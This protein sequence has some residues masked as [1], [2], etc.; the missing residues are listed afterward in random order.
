M[1]GQS[2]GLSDG[3]RSVNMYKQLLGSPD[4]MRQT[5]VYIPDTHGT[6]IYAYI[7]VVEQASMQTYYVYSYSIHSIPGTFISC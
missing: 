1:Q 7:G 3:T 6:A 5:C 4:H 2:P